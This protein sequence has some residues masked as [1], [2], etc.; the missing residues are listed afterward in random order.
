MFLF[1]FNQ[2]KKR[3]RTED[4]IAAKIEKDAERSD[5]VPGHHPLLLRDKSMYRAERSVDKVEHR[6]TVEI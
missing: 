1:A 6:I 4:D 3:S 5:V 2:D